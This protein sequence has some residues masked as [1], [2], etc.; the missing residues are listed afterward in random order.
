[1]DTTKEVIADAVRQYRVTDSDDWAKRFHGVEAPVIEAFAT[2][3]QTHDV[4]FDGPARLH[5]HGSDRD[6]SVVLAHVYGRSDG[7]RAVVD[8]MVFDEAGIQ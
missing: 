4:F 8:R 5:F 3:F 1:M 6:E 2:D 7:R